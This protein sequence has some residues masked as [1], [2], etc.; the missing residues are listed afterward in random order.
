MKKPV[1]L[2]IGMG[3]LYLGGTLVDADDLSKNRSQSRVAQS[4]SQTVKPKTVAQIQTEVSNQVFTQIGQYRKS[5][6]LAGLRSQPALQK[7]ANQRA[8]ELFV[9]FSHTRPN[10]RSGLATPSDYGYKGISLVDNLGFTYY[11]KSLEWYRVN[12]AKTIMQ[13]WI[14]SPEHNKNLINRQP[15][16]GAVGIAFKK[17]GTDR[18]DM[19]FSYLGGL[20]RSEYKK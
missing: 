20:Q 10:G 11:G 4:T 16:E 15:T 7:A 19:T 2:L 1:S 9:K 13:G 6:G 18:Y 8:N 17:V 12:G 14:N 3:M 5:R